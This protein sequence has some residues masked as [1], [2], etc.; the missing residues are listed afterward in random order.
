MRSDHRLDVL[1]GSD[2]L[3][4]TDWQRAVEIAHF[5]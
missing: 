3:R 4:L 1:N 2:W 5:A